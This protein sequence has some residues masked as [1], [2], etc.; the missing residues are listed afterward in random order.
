MDEG[1]RRIDLQEKRRTGQFLEWRKE[2]KA[3]KSLSS[4]EKGT[5]LPEFLRAE[6]ALCD[7]Q[8]TSALQL[9]GTRQLRLKLSWR[10]AE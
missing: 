1:S 8:G 2:K 10:A 4:F 5:A 7:P 3:F 6:G 9:M